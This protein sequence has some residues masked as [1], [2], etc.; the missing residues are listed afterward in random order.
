MDLPAAYARALAAARP[1]LPAAAAA[2]STARRVGR[3]IL[4]SLPLPA[5]GT[6]S[7]PRGSAASTPPAT[8][9]TGVSVTTV[10]DPDS[11]PWGTAIPIG[12]PPPRPTHPP[13]RPAAR[14]HDTAGSRLLQSGKST[15]WISA[16]GLLLQDL[17]PDPFAPRDHFAFS[18][19]RWPPPRHVPERVGVV[20]APLAVGSWGHWMLDVLPALLLLREHGGPI[21]R[22]L[23]SR[24]LTGYEDATLLEAGIDPASV[25]PL[26]DGE[27][28][29]FASALTLQPLDLNHGTP[30]WAADLLRSRLPVSAPSSTPRRLFLSRAGAASR[31][32]RNSGEIQSVLDAADF[33]TIAP[34][35]LP[36]PV[37][38]GLLAGADVIA[39][40]AGS[41]LMNLMFCRPGTRLLLL[42]APTHL[43]P[44]YADLSAHL[45]LHVWS[46]AGKTPAGPAAR[47][48]IPRHDDFLVP[49]PD[50]QAALDR[51]LA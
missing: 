16:D 31:H 41:A 19:L 1:L 47:T 12:Q 32:I 29:R 4:R 15:A 6:S 27:H 43:H 44:V 21:D 38:R 22:W 33:T 35:T 42:H 51:V 50:L 23:V 40:P 8:P 17:S 7:R 24:R 20:P 45:G 18:R 11:R 10:H 9:P 39:A 49:P 30:G 37:Q 28:L 46:L 48:L 5:A 25:T 3:R 26:P 36:L 14:V 34:E 13:R 2:R